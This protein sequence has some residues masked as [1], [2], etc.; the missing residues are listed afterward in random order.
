MVSVGSVGKSIKCPKCDRRLRVPKDAVAR[1]RKQL[2]EKEVEVSPK[3]VGS[4]QQQQSAKLRTRLSSLVDVPEPEAP[5]VLEPQSTKPQLST[6]DVRPAKPSGEKS[7]D[8]EAKKKRR[9]KKKAKAERKERKKKNRAA[10][11]APPR[12]EPPAIVDDSPPIVEEG[13]S[14]PA[15]PQ[16]VDASARESEADEAAV[17][18]VLPRSKADAAPV[19]KSTSSETVAAFCEPEDAVAKPP[20]LQ[21]LSD[22]D[23]LPVHGYQADRDKVATVRWLAAALF[24][25][26]LL[27]MVP[28]VQEIT[29]H[30]QLQDG[31]LLS[32][33]VYVTLLVG[34]LQLAYAGYL[35]QLP[36]WSSVWVVTAFSLLVAGVYAAMFCVTLLAG[37]ENQ[38]VQALDLAERL[39]GGKATGWCLVMLCVTGLLA[40]SGGRVGSRW[41]QAFAM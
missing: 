16:P 35:V 10:G 3:T 17:E 25:I 22:D 33:W 29:A 32:R 27:G 14:S 34:G 9:K 24:G 37:N 7:V 4:D 8:R 15:A 21:S 31:T 39:R 38:F 11:P 12:D 13:E 26:A 23:D 30:L 20:P 5:P 36:D 6:P 41:R 18:K 40:Y 19:E 1:R 2:A 28:A